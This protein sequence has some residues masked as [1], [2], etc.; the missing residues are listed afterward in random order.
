MICFI[1]P[2]GHPRCLCFHSSFNCDIFRSNRTSLSV[3]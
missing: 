3:I 1:L 2:Q